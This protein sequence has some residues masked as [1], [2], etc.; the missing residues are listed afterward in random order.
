MLLSNFNN[1]Q[2]EGEVIME[3]SLDQNDPKHW[4]LNTKNLRIFI[5]PKF[6]NSP[7]TDEYEFTNKSE[8]SKIEL[9]QHDGRIV[10]I[11]EPNTLVRVSAVC[12]IKRPNE[13]VDWFVIYTHKREKK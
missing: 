2:K 13:V 1:F 5:L 11:I 10:T 7:I 8:E 3:Q 6:I 9:K 12:D 4:I